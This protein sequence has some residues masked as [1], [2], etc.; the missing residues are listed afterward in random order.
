VSSFLDDIRGQGSAL[1]DLVG[2]GEQIAKAVSAID[3]DSFDRIV[4]S[5]MGGSHYAS[6][7]AWL[8]LVAN[9]KPAW[10]LETSEILHYAPN[11]LGA[12]TLLWLTSQSGESV[13]VFEL[14]RALD[15]TR[16]PTVLGLTNTPSSTLATAADVVIE[17]Y[18]GVENAVSTRTYV[19]TLGAFALALSAGNVEHVIQTLDHAAHVLDAWL[20]SPEP[21]I[22]RASELLA[23]TNSLIIVGRGPSLAAARAGAL[24]IKEAAKVHAE[25]L[26]AGEFRHGPI[27]LVNANVTIA[28]LAG[29]ESTAALNCALAIDLHSYGARVLWIGDSAPPTIASL[30]YPDTGPDVARQIADIVALQICSV[31]L[32]RRGGVEPGVFRFASKVTTVQ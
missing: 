14:L 11:L 21:A 13:E 27:E 7:P 19:N 15:P 32:A 30:P 5:G 24:T 31:A 29:D 20:E 12:R 3:L 2:H 10:W 17:L 23:E 26:S 25:A 28:I 22:A 18:A 9:G 4:V 6:Y 1:H 8:R 16:R